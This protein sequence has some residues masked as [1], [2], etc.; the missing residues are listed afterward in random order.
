MNK[1]NACVTP[2]VALIRS[3]WMPTANPQGGLIVPNVKRRLKSWPRWVDCDSAIWICW[4]ELEVNLKLVQML[5]NVWMM[6]SWILLNHCLDLYLMVSLG[7]LGTFLLAFTFRPYHDSFLFDVS[8]MDCCMERGNGQYSTQNKGG[9]VGAGQG[10]L[11]L[12]G[13]MRRHKTFNLRIATF[14]LDSN[15]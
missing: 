7:A 6:E 14:D 3:Q 13:L 2:E 8:N 15:M 9:A 5:L 10:L 11:Q 4:G 12:I 1:K